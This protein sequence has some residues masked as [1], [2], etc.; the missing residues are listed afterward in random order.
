M[1]WSQI[2]LVVIGAGCLLSPL[3]GWA[4]Q[5]MPSIKLPTIGI[6]GGSTAVTENSVASRVAEWETL[7]KSCEK[8][9]CKEAAKSLRAMFQNL[10]GDVA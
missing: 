10:A 8:A 4:W 7:L 1:N 9:G 2:L 3:L 5:K 6:G